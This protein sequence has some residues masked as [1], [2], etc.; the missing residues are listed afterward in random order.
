MAAKREVSATVVMNILRD[1]CV[2]P[3]FCSLSSQKI[4]N[5]RISRTYIR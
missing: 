2:K 1:G 4:I 5:K 3:D